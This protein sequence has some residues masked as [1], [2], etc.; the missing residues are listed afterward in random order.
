MNYF[1]ILAIVSM[2][3]I[4]IYISHKKS[5]NILITAEEAKDFS[6]QAIEIN[7]INKEKQLLQTLKKTIKTIEAKIWLFSKRGEKMVYINIHYSMFYNKRQEY[8]DKI[9]KHF[10][11]LGFKVDTYDSGITIH[12]S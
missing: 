12:W 6:D 11:D 2:I 9:K 8:I 3:I 10:T 1:I 4:C 5:N 7:K